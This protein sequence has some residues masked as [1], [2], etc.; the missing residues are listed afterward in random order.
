MQRER[1]FQR[2]WRLTSIGTRFERSIWIPKIL[3]LYVLSESAGGSRIA[4]RSILQSLTLSGP[5][6]ARGPSRHR[7]PLTRVR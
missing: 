5:I 4:K 1:R 7:R 3:T 6:T 2:K